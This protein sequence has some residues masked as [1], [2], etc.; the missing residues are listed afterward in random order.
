MDMKREFQDALERGATHDSLVEIVR[1]HKQGGMTQRQSYDALQ[2]I[3]LEKGFDDDDGEEENPVRDELEAV[4]E[5]VWGFCPSQR[6]IWDTPLSDSSTQQQI[7]Q[8]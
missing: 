3:W 6:A 7:N 5:I 2:E 1:R 8:P 4:M